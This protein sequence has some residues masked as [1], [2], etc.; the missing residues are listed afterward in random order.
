MKF[1]KPIF[2]HEG[3]F[4]QPQ[5]FQILDLHHQHR[6][7]QIPAL[8]K[9]YPWGFL[10]LDIRRAALENQVFELDKFEAIFP[11]GTYVKVPGNGRIVGKSFEGFWS[12]EGKPLSVYIGLRKWYEDRPNVC[13]SS[14]AA[15]L[16]G[17]LPVN[18][19]TRFI[20]DEVP[21]SVGDIFSHQ[22]EAQVRFL[23]HN[24]EVFFEPELEE[25]GDVELLKVAEL[26]RAEEEVRIDPGY[27]P[28]LFWASA[29]KRLWSFVKEI[30]DL[31]TSRG[32]EFAA[33]KKE[34]LGQVPQFGSQD[35]LFLLALRSLNRYIPLFHQITELERIHPVELYGLLRQLVGE[36]SSFSSTYDS[37]GSSEEEPEIPAYNHRDPWPCFRIVRERIVRLLNE[38]TTGPEY[39]IDLLFDGTY[40]SSDLEDRI[41]TDVNRYYLV[42]E[43]SLDKN[44]I[45]SMVEQ[46]A[47]I[48]SREQLPF[49]I[50]RALPGLEARNLP[51]PPSELPR[52]PRAT[53]FELDT[54]SEH[55]QRIR[56]GLNI[57]IFFESPLPDL[58]AQLMVVY[59]R[60]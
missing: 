22:S 16:K 19:Q 13:A 46:T 9:D 10:D 35:L 48:G 11:D 17:V 43:S 14:E 58:K 7:S 6:E 29:S 44:E 49:L 26:V 54:H 37:L 28:P 42:L 34:Q 60:R 32:Q 8:L 5:H 23:F 33:Y 52:R 40:Y 51:V 39:V 47:K 45:I 36:L 41:F 24:V 20:V 59:E 1:E 27:V 56:E 31:L 38:I 50:A 2:W 53:Y 25:A 30:R 18:G 57:G 4:L 15:S 3:L 21:E 55:W 12:A